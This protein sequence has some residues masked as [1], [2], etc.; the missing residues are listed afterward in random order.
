[1]GGSVQ[2]NQVELSATLMIWACRV[3]LLRRSGQRSGDE[4]GHI[5]RRRCAGATATPPRGRELMR[6]RRGA[7]R[8]G[9]GY[10]AEGGTD[11]AMA[12]TAAGGCVRS[13]SRGARTTVL[14]PSSSLSFGNDGGVSGG[15]IPSSK[16]AASTQRTAGDSVGV[17]FGASFSSGGGGILKALKAGSSGIIPN[18]ASKA[19]R[20]RRRSPPSISAD[21][22]GALDGRP[23][24]T[25][26]GRR[27]Y[28]PPLD[29]PCCSSGPPRGRGR[30]RQ[31][32]RTVAEGAAMRRRERTQR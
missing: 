29:C 17:S 32:R 1:M 28:C 2:R 16:P 5:Q 18:K 19:G 22:V 11:A 12:K 20:W 9:D 25:A 27:S 14:L 26:E 13:A 21:S 10:P 23:Q 24:R 3:R 8:G 4:G 15:A 31:G 30:R 6:R 7:A